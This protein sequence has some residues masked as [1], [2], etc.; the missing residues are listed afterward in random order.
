MLESWIRWTSKARLPKVQPL[1]FNYQGP[2]LWSPFIAILKLF[3]RQIGQF[4][5]KNECYDNFFCI[6]RFTYFEPKFFFTF[7]PF[8]RQ[9]KN[10]NIEPIKRIT[11][12]LPLRNI[13]SLVFFL[14]LF[15]FYI[16]SVLLTTLLTGMSWSRLR[17][18]QGFG[19]QCAA[20]IC[21]WI[22]SRIRY[23]GALH[24][25]TKYVNLL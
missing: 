2:M 15:P 18:T 17:D 16:C 1:A 22:A 9:L 23:Y 24:G 6:S 19:M 7:P 12:I 21:S 13:F 4:S 5:L 14:L 3:R 25:L 20:Y 11:F 8:F 10:R